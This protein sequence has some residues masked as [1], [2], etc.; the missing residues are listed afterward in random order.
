MKLL[1]YLL[2]IQYCK[3]NNKGICG[4]KRYLEVVRDYG[5][6][7]DLNDLCGVDNGC[8]SSFKTPNNSSYKPGRH[9]K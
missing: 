5:I 8:F 1:I 9:F 3:R 2:S 4:C 7:I 6:W